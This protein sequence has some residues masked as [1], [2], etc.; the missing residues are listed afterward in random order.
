[1][2]KP[3]SKADIERRVEF[4]CEHFSLPGI[5]NGSDLVSGARYRDVRPR[6]LRIFFRAHVLGPGN[7]AEPP[8]VDTWGQDGVRSQRLTYLRPFVLPAN[9][10]GMTTH[11]SIKLRTRNALAPESHI[12]WA[13]HALESLPGRL[14]LERATFVGDWT[15]W[16]FVPEAISKTGALAI[17]GEIQALLRAAGVGDS[18]YQIPISME[19]QESLPLAY[20]FYGGRFFGEMFAVSRNGELVELRL[21]DPKAPQVHRGSPAQTPSTDCHL[22]ESWRAQFGC[23]WVRAGEL[24]G[25]LREGCAGGH[26]GVIQLG[27]RLKRLA[28]SRDGAFQIETRRSGNSHVFRLMS[29]FESHRGENDDVATDNN[30]P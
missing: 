23:R 10:D 15:I 2:M 20:P 29:G 5:L 14:V 8:I 30:D 19:T 4:L 27:S 9:S 17:A 21:V 1:M 25:L 22:F 28:E 18:D 13:F 16:L 24:Q 6:D 26:Q 11:V 12:I 7:G 3:L